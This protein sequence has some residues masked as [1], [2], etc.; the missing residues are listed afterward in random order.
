MSIHRQSSSRDGSTCFLLP[1]DFG[2]NGNAAMQ[3]TL[4]SGAG[5]I[6]DVDM[7]HGIAIVER[8]MTTTAITRT[9]TTITMTTTTMAMTMTTMTI[10]TV[11]V[12]VVMVAP[13]TEAAAAAAAVVAA[14]V[15]VGDGGGMMFSLLLHSAY[16]NIKDSEKV[17]SM[18]M[19][20]TMVVTMRV[21]ILPMGRM[22]MVEHAC[23]PRRPDPCRPYLCRS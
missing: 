10:T 15:V 13:A 8:S 11:V 14:V 22:A 9:T 18:T 7:D 1:V 16:D 6:Y 23:S 12:L 17:M 21:I 19:V 4:R 20:A 2:G 3:R 5:A